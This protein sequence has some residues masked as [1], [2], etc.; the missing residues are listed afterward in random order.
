M[1]RPVQWWDRARLARP[2]GFCC[3]ADRFLGIF[4]RLLYDSRGDQ[5]ASSRGAPDTVTLP[6][7]ERPLMV[8]SGV[9]SDT[10][11]ELHDRCT[12]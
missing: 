8:G 6:N 4:C 1:R 12:G 7:W 11:L 5:S 10:Q 2:A 9:R 3:L